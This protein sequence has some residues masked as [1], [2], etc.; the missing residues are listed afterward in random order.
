VSTTFLAAY[1]DADTPIRVS[2]A[3]GTAG[4]P[5]AGCARTGA[6]KYTTVIKVNTTYCRSD[7]G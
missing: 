4:R 7:R 5:F 6:A 3:A 1:P 2:R